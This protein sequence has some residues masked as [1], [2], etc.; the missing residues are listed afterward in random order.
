MECFGCK[1]ILLK[2]LKTGEE[3]QGINAEADELDWRQVWIIRQDNTHTHTDK[4]S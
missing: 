2:I 1:V 3:T 4:G